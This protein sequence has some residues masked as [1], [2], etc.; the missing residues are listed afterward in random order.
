[1]APLAAARAYRVFFDWNKADL[2]DRTLQ[3]IG[4]AASAPG[5]GVTRLEVSG[6]TNGS[7]STQ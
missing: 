1:V 2:T 7:G 3:I 6:Y 4:E 5:A